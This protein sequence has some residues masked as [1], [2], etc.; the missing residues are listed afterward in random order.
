MCKDHPTNLP[1]GTV[2]VNYKPISNKNAVG[3]IISFQCNEGYK[4]NSQNSFYFCRE[5][6]AW[7]NEMF[8]L[9][10]LKGKKLHN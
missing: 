8:N 1:N 7:N 5:N 9:T 2:I 10:C 6:G 4:L 3:T